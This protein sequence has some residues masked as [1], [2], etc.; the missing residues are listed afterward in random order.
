MVYMDK[1]VYMVYKAGRVYKNP[2]YAPAG[3]PVYVL[4]DAQACVP[5]Q[6][7]AF[8]PALAEV[9]SR[10]LPLVFAPGRSAEY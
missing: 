8:F 3:I 7:Q 4:D 9:L 10:V 1:T 5:A 2:V 6:F